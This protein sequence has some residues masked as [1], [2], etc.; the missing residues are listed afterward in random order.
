MSPAKAMKCL[1]GARAGASHRVFVDLTEDD[2]VSTRMSASQQV[3]KGGNSGSRKRKASNAAEGSPSTEK[4]LRVYRA[5]AP[6]AFHDIFERA[7]SQRFYVI[8]RSRGGTAVCPEE[9][10]EVTG[11]TGNIY[12]VIVKQQP[13]CNCPHARKGNQCKHVIF[14]LA[15][16]LRAPYHLV[17]QLALLESELRE[18]FEKAPS[19]ESSDPSSTSGKRKPIEDDCPICF[20]ELDANCPDSIVWCKAACG[21]NIHQECFET[22]A[23]TQSGD[24]TCPLCRSKWEGD[25]DTISR[26]RKDKGTHSEGYVNVAGQLGISSTRDTS[27]YSP[28]RKY[29]L[30]GARSRMYRRR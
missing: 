3:H 30:Y 12:T 13:T 2:D 19:V 11:S 10:F 17:Y 7:L 6:K 4:R 15:R 20:C 8:G 28:W 21:Q 5:A 9:T 24:V 26:V 16:V 29:G 23:R 25:P 14:V 1:Q 27:T 22:W 18:I